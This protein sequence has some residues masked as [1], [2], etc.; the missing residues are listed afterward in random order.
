[1]AKLPAQSVGCASGPGD[2]ALPWPL[3]HVL[4]SVLV[5][6]PVQGKE[7]Q[8]NRDSP[9]GMLEGWAAGPRPPAGVSAL[10]GVGV[11]RERVTRL[12]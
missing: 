3:M 1:M 9:C 12:C 6:L 8:G 10:V 11:G 5:S 4:A 2:Q 7:S